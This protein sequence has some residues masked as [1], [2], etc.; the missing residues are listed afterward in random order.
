[1]NTPPQSPVCYTLA[2][3]L[4]ALEEVL[5]IARTDLRTLLTCDHLPVGGDV[6]IDH[7]RAVVA[8]L[9][10]LVYNVRSKIA[11]RELSALTI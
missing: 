2:Q 10:W 1:M 3:E 9:E 4:E 11:I 7:E 8:D 6:L 5:D